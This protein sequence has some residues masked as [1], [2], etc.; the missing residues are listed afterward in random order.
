MGSMGFDT[1]KNAHIG[2]RSR[3]STAV[4]ATEEECVREMARCLRETSEG[5]TPK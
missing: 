3:E 2:R 1:T 5:R 4:D